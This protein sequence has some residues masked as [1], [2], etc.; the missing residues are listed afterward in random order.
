MPGLLDNLNFD[1][2]K[3]VGLLNMA[4]Q[5]MEAGGPSRVPVSFGQALS[6]G[7]VGGLQGYQGAQENLQQKA[8]R[9]LQAKRAGL[10]MQQL[11]GQVGDQQKVRDFYSNLSQF[12]PSQEQQ[13]LTAGAAVGDVGPTVGNAARIPQMPQQAF[14]AN[15]MY[16]AMLRSGSPTL[17]AQGLQGMSKDDEG[18]VVSEGSSL[19]GKRSGK[20]L[21]AN[22][23]QEKPLE[24]ERML[25]AAGI[26]D[27][28]VRSRYISQALNKQVTHAPASSV[29]NFLGTKETFKNERDLRNDFQGLP[30]TKA[31]REVQGAYDQINFALKNPSAANDLA[32]ATKFMK[33]LDPGSVVRE[34]ELAMAM[35]AT[36]LLD[37]VNNYADMM[38]KGYKLTPKQREDFYKSA[39]GLYSA[40]SNRYNDAASEFRTI[41]SDYGL[42]A[43]RIA[44]PATVNTQTTIDSLLKKYGGN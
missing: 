30:T 2:P 39:E 36:G 32:A 9:D 19:V 28:L 6:R 35:S 29:N 42:N 22:P 14:D 3:T 18:V 16:S 38:A 33:L 34:S 13:A 12:M 24:L 43:D 31:F 44:K 15:A 25:D 8:I 7:L 27:P 21:F 10:E 26:K 41:A 1:D 40:A 23:K 5:M 37:R 11:E 17:A 4:A 20:Q